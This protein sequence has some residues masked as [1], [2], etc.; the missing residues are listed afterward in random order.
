MFSYFTLLI[1]IKVNLLN[2]N[3]RKFEIIK[4]V[5]ASELVIFFKH[6]NKN[7]NFKI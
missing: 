6:T 7:I 2:L 3:I 1:A 4:E 5:F